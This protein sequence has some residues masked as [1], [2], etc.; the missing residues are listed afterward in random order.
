MTVWRTDVENV[1][2]YPI[3]FLVWHPRGYCTTTIDGS[4]EWDDQDYKYWMP[5][6]GS[7]VDGG[8]EHG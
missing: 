1:P 2:K 5:L 3:E 4:G 7:P 6:P 8:A